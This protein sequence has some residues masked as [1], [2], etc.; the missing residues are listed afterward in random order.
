VI[1][2][3]ARTS[4][5]PRES[6]A[7]GNGPVATPEIHDYHYLVAPF[8]GQLRAGQNI[9][10]VSAQLR[11]LINHYASYG[12]ELVEIGSVSLTI[13]EGCIGALLGRSSSQHSY[14][15]VIFRRRIEHGE[16]G[17]GSHE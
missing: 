7:E 15:Q 16:E 1:L 11:D 12:W 8:H 4:P 13:N 6:A 2:S 3:K 17:A 14:D 9:T 5:P 10:N